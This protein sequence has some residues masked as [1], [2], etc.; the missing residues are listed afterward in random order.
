MTIYSKI[1]HFIISIILKENKAKAKFETIILERFF[2]Y[3]F[4]KKLKIK[5]GTEHSHR[6]REAINNNNNRIINLVTNIIQQYNKKP[7][8]KVT[9][10]NLQINKSL[11]HISR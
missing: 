4:L 2:V 1:L 5:D 7:T 6:I 8:V 9:Q 11:Y 3:D 10:F